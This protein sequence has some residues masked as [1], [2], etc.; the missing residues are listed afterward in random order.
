MK[1]HNEDEGIGMKCLYKNINLSTLKRRIWR[2]CERHA[3]TDG[4]LEGLGHLDTSIMTHN[5]FLAALCRI[6]KQGRTSLPLPLPRSG[7]LRAVV[8]PATWRPL[9]VTN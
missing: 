7:P 9:S 1:N 2:K 5:F 8:P 4:E 3:E 6:H